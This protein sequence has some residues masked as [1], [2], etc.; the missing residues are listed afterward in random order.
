MSISVMTLVWR[1]A[2]YQGNA[3]LALLALADWSDDKGVSW[4]AVE[5][6][7]K[8]SRQ[9]E[10]QAQRVLHRL[11]T[12]GFLKIVQRHGTSSR[13]VINIHKLEGCH[14]VTPDKRRQRGD[15]DGAQMS[16]YTSLEPSLKAYR[17]IPKC[18]SCNDTQK[19][20]VMGTGV[21]DS[22]E[23]CGACQVAVV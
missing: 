15:I 17:G 14:G 18:K 23:P 6:L 2:P 8:K 1:T 13:Y 22:V 11:A 19:I 16:P 9:S 4:P 5:T 20:R 7:A 12:D 21:E 3:L 10:R